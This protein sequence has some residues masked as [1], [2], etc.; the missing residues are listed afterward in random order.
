MRELFSRFQSLLTFEYKKKL[1]TS[2][3]DNKRNVILNDM[4]I[5]NRISYFISRHC[6]SE[7]AK[8]S[9]SDVQLSCFMELSLCKVSELFNYR[10]QKV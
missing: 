8:N 1:L 6:I 9:I 10:A 5:F 4:G 7:L 3:P 2:L